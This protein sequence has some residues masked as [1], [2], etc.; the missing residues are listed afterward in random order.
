MLLPKSYTST[1]VLLFR[2]QPLGTQLF[3][4]ATNSAQQDSI[5]PN[6]EAATNVSLV[7]LP[8]IT[9]RTA[10]LMPGHPSPDAVQ[11]HVNVQAQGKSDTVA[12]SATEQNPRLATLLASTFA[13]QFISFRRDTDRSSVLQ[14]LHVVDQQLAGLPPDELASPRGRSLQQRRDDLAIL[15]S[16]QT[17]N[18]QLVQPAQVPNKPSFPNITQNIGLGLLLGLVLGVAG[19]LVFDRLDRRFRSV[20]EVQSAF[21]RPLIGTIPESSAFSLQ[22]PFD[23]RLSTPGFE[24]FGLLWANLRFFGSGD[25]VRSV[26]IT[27]TTR[28]EGKSTV[29][30]HLAA[31]A[32][33]TGTKVVLVEIDLREPTLAERLD[34]DRSRGLSYVLCGRASSEEVTT[35]IPVAAANNGNDAGY[36]LDVIP[37]NPIPPNPADLIGSDAMR[38]VLEKL[39][40]QYDLVVVD[41]PPIS[42]VSDAIPVTKE[43]SGILT[44]SRLNMTD[45]QA[46]RRLASQL[47]N[48]GA[49]HLGVVVNSSG[50]DGGY[51]Y[52]YY[53]RYPTAVPVQSQ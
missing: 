25:L 29:A 17:G 13:D 48:L 53:R 7:S 40:L 1:A 30:L 22:T 10:A 14:T 3:S 31:A 35:S 20:E 12:I 47:D 41:A 19:A 28:G 49:C 36:L 33:M 45:R 6:R 16:L 18:A 42:I 9:D 2:T 38:G 50:S 44:V 39:G 24:S 46:A 34:L 51:G 43:V 21:G 15:S 37:G 23:T 11:K 5:D 32:A 4:S 52:G 8:I 27:S 26:L